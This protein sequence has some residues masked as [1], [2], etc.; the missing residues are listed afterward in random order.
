M[1]LETITM[2]RRDV[3]ALAAIIEQVS[4]SVDNPDYK[5]VYALKLTLDSIRP[6]V[7]AVRAAQKPA[8]A[9]N[10]FERAREELA[11]EYAAKGEG[12][13]AKV[14]VM[15]DGTSVYVMDPEREKEF[16]Q[17]FAE[18][19]ETHRE[20]ISAEDDRRL[21]FDGFLRDDVSVRVQR[22]PLRLVPMKKVTAQQL[23][24]LT[25]LFTDAAEQAGFQAEP[26]AAGA[27]A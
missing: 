8:T 13:E 5:L 26:A 27:E 25:P 3:L 4:A 1:A 15:G 20:A 18:L 14:R 6:E 2:Q 21:G 24:I 16:N 10:A 11:V 12:G 7:D 9:F 17:R 23:I 19:R 22:F